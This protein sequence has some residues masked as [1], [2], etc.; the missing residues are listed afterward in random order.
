MK[1]LLITIILTL[2]C[3]TPVELEYFQG[4]NAEYEIYLEIF[5]S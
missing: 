2:S 5:F 3:S 1:I 4:T